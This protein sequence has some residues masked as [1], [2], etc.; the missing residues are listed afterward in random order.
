[1]GQESAPTGRRGAS[2]EGDRGTWERDK[3]A[4]R[5]GGL[6][7]GGGKLSPGVRETGCPLLQSCLLLSLCCD[8]SWR[9]P[10][11]STTLPSSCAAQNQGRGLDCPLAARRF[12]VW[13][14]CFSAHCP[15]EGAVFLPALEVVVPYVHLE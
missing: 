5:G 7:G 10:V 15:A 4:C 13:C 2:S 14:V 11:A 1:M 12:E 6:Q 9:E 3:P 8:T